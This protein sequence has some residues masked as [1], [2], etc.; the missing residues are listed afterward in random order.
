VVGGYS[1][2]EVCL[3]MEEEILKERRLDCEEGGLPRGARVVSEGGPYFSCWFSLV[4]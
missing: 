1:I 3:G 2:R 4:S